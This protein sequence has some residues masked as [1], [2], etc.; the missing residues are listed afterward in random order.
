GLVDYDQ[1]GHVIKESVASNLPNIV[2]ASALHSYSE[3]IHD[4]QTFKSP[5]ILTPHPGEFS[6]LTG[7]SIKNI[8]K[9]NSDLESDYAT[10]HKVIVV[11]KGKNTI[12][13]FKNIQN[14]INTTGNCSLAKGVKGN[15]HTCMILSMVSYYKDIY[16]AFINAVYIHGL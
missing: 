9:N 7:Y 8:L 1:A 5:V 6:V 2:D 14:Y 3:G 15:V 16:Q 11:L 13:A 12:I 10:R 4:V